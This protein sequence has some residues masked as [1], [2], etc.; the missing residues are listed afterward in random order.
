MPK[1]SMAP[2][3]FADRLAMGSEAE[4]ARAKAWLAVLL[5]PQAGDAPGGAAASSGTADVGAPCSKELFIFRYGKKFSP[6]FL[7]SWKREV[8]SK[9][10][11]E[12]RIEHRA[13]WRDPAGRLTI[14]LEC[15]EYRDF[16]AIEYVMFARNDGQDD[17]DILEEFYSL[18]AAWPAQGP[19]SVLHRAEGSHA[20]QSDFLYEPVR[21]AVQQSYRNFVA[22][23]GRSSNDHLPFWNLQTDDRGVMVALGWSGQWRT[24]V[25]WSMDNVLHIASKQDTLRARLH[26]GEEIRTPRVLLMFWQGDSHIR[27][28]NMQRRWIITHRSPRPNGKLLTAPYCQSSWG[29]HTTA[30]H[31]DTLAQIKGKTRHEY[32]WIDAGWYGYG[33]PT[34]NEHVGDWYVWA[35]SWNVNPNVHPNGFTP[36]VDEV[37]AQGK[38]FL[39]WFDSERAYND[40]DWYKQ[41]PEFFLGAAQ[42]RGVVLL[43]LGNPQARRFLTDFICRKIEEFRIDCYRHDMNVDPLWFWNSADGPDRQGITENHYVQGLYAWW[44]EMLA[45]F[46]HLLIDNCCSGGRRIDLE[47]IGRSIAL[48]R[49][50]FQCYPEAFDGQWDEPAQTQLM[51]LSYWIPLFGIGA[52]TNCDTYNFRGNLG[53]ALTVN[54]VGFNTPPYTDERFAWFKQMEEQYLRA[55]PFFYGDYYPLTL[56]SIH[57]DTW[58]SMQYDR[59]D[60][61]EG[62]VLIFRRVKNRSP[63]LTVSLG[64]LDP[65]A[66]Y[67]L[68]DVDTRTT[69]TATGRELLDGWTITLDQPRTSRMVFYRKLP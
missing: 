27:G 24:N 31:L 37:R 28:H 52:R 43:N 54:Y 15:I 20:G 47:T 55:R 29:G 9:P 38:K 51:G 65:S 46:P 8:S 50:D 61:G 4:F 5:P 7:A 23:N 45:R 32:Y 12:Q 17:T 19:T 36:I 33:Q 58:A 25:W 30:A 49:S 14:R 69:G 62:L 1:A 64:G 10:L 57:P 60:L 68:D 56:N 16:P 11:D 66:T 22:G 40:S 35:G 63:Q 67:E 34:I 2:G 42:P 48:W 18:H 41:H 26:P 6:E 13:C 3:T 39:L 59:P 44:D 21:L 53:A